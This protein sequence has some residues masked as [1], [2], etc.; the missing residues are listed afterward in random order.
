VAEPRLATPHNRSNQSIDYQVLVVVPCCFYLFFGFVWFSCS[1]LILD[2]D[3]NK[4]WKAQGTPRNQLSHQ[5]YS[6]AEPSLA[7]PHNRSD[8][9]IDYL[10]LVVCPC[11]FYL[12]F[13]F[14][15]VL[16]VF[17][18]AKQRKQENMGKPRNTKKSRFSS[19]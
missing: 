7:P 2:Q 17:L 6:V 18:I 4:T 3:N 5:S 8:Q 12:F 13:V 19:N 10:V 15:W 16:L 9:S 14:G 11:C 1:F